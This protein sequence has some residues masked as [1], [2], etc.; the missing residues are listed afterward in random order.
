MKQAN[1]KMS[2]FHMHLAFSFA[3][4]EAK[5]NRNECDDFKHIIHSKCMTS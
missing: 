4:T 2:L 3:S 5:K 1:E